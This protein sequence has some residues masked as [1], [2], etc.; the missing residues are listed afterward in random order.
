MLYWLFRLEQAVQS[1]ETELAEAKEEY[2]SL[3]SNMKQQSE[4]LKKYVYFLCI[5]TICT[6]IHTPA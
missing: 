6:C 3:E 1:K 2:E 4:E 5:S